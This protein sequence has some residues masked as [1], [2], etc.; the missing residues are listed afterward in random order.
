MDTAKLMSLLRDRLFAPVHIAWLVIFRIAFGGIMLWEVWRY[1]DFKRISRYYIEPNFHFT[2]YGFGWVQP[3]EGEGM[4]L[5]FYFLGALS[6]C[7]IAGFCYRLAATL[8]FFAFTYVFLLDQTQYLNHFYLVCLISFLM[9][10]VPAHRAFSVDAL[11]RPK[12][13]S[14][15]VPAWTLWLLRVQIGIAYFYAGIAKMGEDWLRGEPMRTWLAARMDFPVIG[16]YFDQEWAVYFFVVGGMLLD[17]FVVPGL[18]WKRTRPFAFAA[19]VSFHLLNAR[20]FS[21]GIFPWFM[22]CATLLFFPS[23]L[24]RR[25]WYWLRRKP[26]AEQT[27]S[28]P[29]AAVTAPQPW[30]RSQ[31]VVLTLLSLYLA[32][33]TLMPLRH[34][35]YPGNVD[36]TEEGHRFAWHMKLRS[37]S[38]DALFLVTDKTNGH[39]MEVYPQEYLNGRQTAKMS[40]RP[41]MI[42]QFAHYLATQ[43]RLQ[44]YEKVE[45]RARVM[46]SLNGRKPQLLVDPE[47]DLAAEKRTLA[48]AKW[49]LP[50]HE[51][52]PKWNAPR[53]LGRPSAADGD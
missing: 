37:K 4:Y 29:A 40:T 13:R 8:F 33:Q 21:I 12:L 14:Y 53:P 18:L 5:H 30:T 48:H 19:A 3:W 10:F 50:L 46:A 42:I 51:P 52:L 11:L 45:V 27:A 23:D 43:M 49:I 1:F 20:L 25:I 17:L 16:P 32:F 15:T 9:I 38:S 22:L 44:G 39:V 28:A 35:L 6:A 7:I 26:P 47:V 36:W 31:K 41:D 24:P 34:Y 2:Y